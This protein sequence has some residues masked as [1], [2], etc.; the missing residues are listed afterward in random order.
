MALSVGPAQAGDTWVVTNTRSQGNGSFAS[1]MDKAAARKNLDTVRFAGKLR[2]DIRVR[3]EIEIP[4]GIR[5]IGNGY[6]RGKR[7]GRVT[8]HGPRTGVRLKFTKGKVHKLDGLDLERVA[9]E[10]T[11]PAGELKITRSTISGDATAEGAGAFM[12]PKNRYT[13]PHL[14]ISDST[15]EGFELGVGVVDAGAR[16]GRSIIRDNI[17]GGGVAALAYSG[18]WVFN[19]TISGNQ[20]DASDGFPRS[21]AGVRGGYYAGANVYNSTLT[22]NSVIG[23]GGYGGAVAYNVEVFESTL[24]GNS[25]PTGGAVGA[26]PDPSQIPAIAGAGDVT[27]SNSVVYGNTATAPGRRARLRRQPSTS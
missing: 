6:G 12:G 9:V 11:F 20:L 17:G 2:G 1:A 27:L 19:S 13:D 14:G 15:I 16:V 5:I 18:V 22:G 26:P 3:R 10:G 21:G 24:T 4:S 23:E 25:A 7:A 8:L